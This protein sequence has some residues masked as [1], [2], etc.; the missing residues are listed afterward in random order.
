VVG[1]VVNR[2]VDLV[3]ALVGVTAPSFQAGPAAGTN[4]T[5]AA[6]VQGPT[7]AVDQFFAVAQ[8]LKP[9]WSLTGA[10]YSPAA[11]GDGLDLWAD[12]GDGHW[13]L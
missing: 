10:K 7:N 11:S 5:Q 9:Q 1:R 13:V 8:E 12:G 3:P 2:N 4:P 6:P